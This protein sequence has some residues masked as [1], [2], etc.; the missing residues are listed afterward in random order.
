MAG[1]FLLTLARGQLARGHD[2]LA[3]A[4]HDAGLPERS[5]I[6]GVRIARYRYGSD[7]QETL[8]YRG[9]MHEQV[10]SSW[11]ARGRLL[12]LLSASRAAVR[13]A[14]REFRPD[15]IHVHWWFPG[16]LAVWPRATGG[17][18]VVLTS[19]GTDLF[20]L[21]R[22]AATRALA[23]P[24]FRTAAEVTVISTPL[25]PRVAALGVDAAHV[26]VVPMP[27]DESTF[28]AD[29]PP[30]HES[31]TLLFV[32]RLIERKGPEYA[33]RAL[34]SLRGAGRDVRLTLVG[35]GPD[36][37]ALE[38]LAGAL[39]VL[40]FVTFTG[41][42]PPA[43]VSRMYRCAAVLLM[44]A[45]TDWKGEQEG[46]GMVI[47]EAMAA[48]VPVVATRS[49][50]IGDIVRDSENG[51][52]VAERDAEGLA[53]AALR[54]LDDAGLARRLSERARADVRE[55]FSAARIA[56]TFDA[57]YRRAAARR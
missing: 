35:D 24:I 37:A 21:D 1:A 16:G 9:N 41:A 6:D 27:M 42:L 8:A 22:S 43:E 44:P 36:R 31:K 40:D 7:A 15:V 50:G 17:A 13:R 34:A 10:F 54:L 46:F 39:G 57:V 5:E 55:R 2:V 53:R 48:G 32:G 20:L 14:E 56:E 33:V 11:R 52:L 30:P 4:P 18:P 25:V 3:L 45:V 49:G 29:G 38:R 47:V 12:R 26:T 28:R 19:H 51:L 23:A